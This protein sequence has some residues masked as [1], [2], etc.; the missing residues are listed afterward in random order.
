MTKP[1]SDTMIQA[2]ADMAE[3][4]ILEHK[5]PYR[6]SPHVIIMLM[7]GLAG[8]A[9]SHEAE[10]KVVFNELADAVVERIGVAKAQNLGARVCRWLTKYRRRQR[11]WHRIPSL[12]RSMRCWSICRSTQTNQD[13]RSVPGPLRTA[14][15]DRTGTGHGRGC[16]HLPRR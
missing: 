12:R 8:A 10:T 14:A 4:L 1:T 2:A 3:V 5:I 9:A 11:H 15:A 7:M 6:H 16:L 13:G